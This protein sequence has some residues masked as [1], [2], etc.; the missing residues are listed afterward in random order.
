MYLIFWSTSCF[1]LSLEEQWRE[2][3]DMLILEASK[4]SALEQQQVLHWVIEQKRDSLSFFCEQ[5]LAQEVAYSCSLFENRPHLLDK[6]NPAPKS[7]LHSYK[8]EERNRSLQEVFLLVQEQESL[9]DIAKMCNSVSDV[10]MRSECYF[11]AADSFHHRKGLQPFQDMISLC[12]ASGSFVQ[13][14]LSHIRQR[15]AYPSFFNEEQWNAWDERF[16][17]LS[18]HPAKQIRNFGADF[19]ARMAFRMVGELTQLCWSPSMDN[20]M[21]TSTIRDALVFWGLY[22]QG[23]KRDFFFSLSHWEESFFVHCVSP[24]Q[25]G[26]IGNIPIPRFI[27]FSGSGVLFFDGQSRPTHNDN[28]IDN[29]FLLLESAYYFRDQFLLRD[30]LKHPFIPVRDRAQKMISELEKSHP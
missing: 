12:L 1:T 22:R 25:K 15:L 9:H 28:N 29:A 21:M 26:Q 19:S 27:P 20:K 30:A 2:S 18:M 3:P 6:S 23:N 17:Y 4:H 5:E 8:A 14:C 10:V 24:P 13:Y 11:V 16:R 7:I